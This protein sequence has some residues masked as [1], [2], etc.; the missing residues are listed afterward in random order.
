[1]HILRSSLFLVAVILSGCATTP[2]TTETA[3]LSA[4]V[5]LAPLSRRSGRR[6]R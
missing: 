1:M 5:R 4:D 6:P 3:N 2:S